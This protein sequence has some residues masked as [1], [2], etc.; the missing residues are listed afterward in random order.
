MD[1]LIDV[2][3]CCDADALIEVD[4]ANLLN[5][6]R[7]LAQLGRWKMPSRVYDELHRGS[8][9]L[10]KRLAEWRK[11]YDLVVELDATA[12]AYLPDIERAYGEDFHLGGVNYS[13]FWKSSS[14]RRSADAQLVALAKARGWIVISNDQSVRGACVLEDVRCSTWETLALEL[15]RL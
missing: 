13:G 3:Y 4:R 15:R 1:R 6:L 5:R 7:K 10:G 9:R 2:V 14:G 11:K 12:L 8:D